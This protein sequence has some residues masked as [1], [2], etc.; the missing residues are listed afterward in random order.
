MTKTSK[1]NLTRRQLA[2]ATVGLLAAQ[3]ARADACS[4]Y[5]SFTC[6]DK[7]APPVP[8]PL[9]AAWLIHT[10]GH[11]LDEFLFGGTIRKDVRACLKLTDAQ[12]TF[13]SDKLSGKTVTL[14]GCT[15]S[16]G[17]DIQN[18]FCIVQSVWASILKDPD[19]VK[20]FKQFSVPYSGHACPK[21]GAVFQL[22]Q[23]DLGTSNASQKAKK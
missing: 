17:A 20:L 4:D 22:A 7:D 14:S 3:S 16:S 2:L 5:S 15:S 18:A 8:G 11:C 19:I 1:T 12:W 6:P 13:L 23:S 9:L 10:T 21:T